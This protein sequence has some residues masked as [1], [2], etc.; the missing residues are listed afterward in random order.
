MTYGLRQKNTIRSYQLC[1][2]NR[3]LP[4]TLWATFGSKAEAESYGQQLEALLKQGII[5]STLLE[6]PMPKQEIWTVTRCIVEYQ[7]HSALALSEVKLLDTIQPQLATVATGCLNYDW[8]ESWI[9]SMKRD[10]NLSPSTIR[11]RQGRWLT[12]GALVVMPAVKRLIK[13][14]MPFRCNLLTARE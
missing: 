3:P 5:P 4:K 11:H 7:R 13:S 14:A 8:A 10:A 9:R 12:A 6:R 1:I 2:R